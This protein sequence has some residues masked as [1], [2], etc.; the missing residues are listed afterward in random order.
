MSSRF[1]PPTYASFFG[2]GYGNAEWFCIKLSLV[3][4]VWPTLLYIAFVR[5]A[6]PYP[7]GICRLINCAAWAQEPLRYA[8][9][10]L[11]AVL[12]VLYLAEKKMALTTFLVFVVSV[13][14][15]SLEASNGEKSLRGIHSLFFL[16]QSLAYLLY[17]KSDTQS[18]YAAR[19]RFSAQF[20]AAV[21]L[22]SAISKWQTAGWGWITESPNMALQVVKS[23]AYT[24]FDTGLPHYAQ[25]G[26]RI[27]GWMARHP[28][29]VKAALLCAW[30][31]EAG[32]FVLLLKKKWAFAYACLLLLM[33]VGILLAMNIYFP[34][35]IYPLVIFFINPL[36]LLYL[37]FK[38]LYAAVRT[39]PVPNTG[40]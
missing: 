18:L 13:L 23:Y 12:A 9:V 37:I 30:L 10:G 14:L 29:A 34:T 36:Y 3:L 31:L 32:S 16:A 2:P 1:T 39:R 4:M 27:A 20:V 40:T 6:Q 38:R 26:T 17:A 19:I 7:D 8:T 25:T 22:L 21:Y 15:F 5:T 11:L 28:G 35:L 33:H 24:T